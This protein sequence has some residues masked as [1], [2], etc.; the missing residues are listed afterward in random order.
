M[1]GTDRTLRPELGEGGRQTHTQHLD[2]STRVLVDDK[3]T[4]GVSSDRTEV[5]EAFPPVGIDL[6]HQRALIDQSERARQA[7]AAHDGHGV[8]TSAGVS[9][10]SCYAALYERVAPHESL[11]VGHHN[12]LD[13]KV[14]VA[15]FEKFPGHVS[16]TI[17]GVDALDGEEIHVVLELDEKEAVQLAAEILA[18][19][20]RTA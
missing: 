15:S 14:E 5:G 11:L 10:R 3:P 2:G 20:N 12:T 18:A 7:G 1:H 17:T 6:A 19:H 4:V 16:L 9:Y 8:T 13:G